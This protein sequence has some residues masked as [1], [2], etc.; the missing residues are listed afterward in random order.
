M[1]DCRARQSPEQL[2]G[3]EG[4]QAPQVSSGRSPL[5][6]P[7]WVL[8]NALLPIPIPWLSSLPS[9]QISLLFGLDRQ[10]GEGI[11]AKNRAGRE[12][13]TRHRSKRRSQKGHSIGTP[14]ARTVSPPRLS[15]KHPH[16]ETPLRKERTKPRSASRFFFSGRR[17]FWQFE[18]LA[19]LQ[20]DVPDG[21]FAK[22]F[23]S[24]I[25]LES[26]AE[27]SAGKSTRPLDGYG[28]G[29]NDPGRDGTLYFHSFSPNRTHKLHFALFIDVNRSGLDAPGN[30]ALHPDTNSSM[31]DQAS[32]H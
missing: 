28:T 16:A 6:K 1:G 13:V 12:Y 29:R 7:A 31:A 22:K 3:C 24:L 32:T 11:S 17:R 21:K 8:H 25:N 5:E 4:P 27:Q 9:V 30:F 15:P 10:L 23:A 19:L 2:H 26:A 20:L 18:Q 14:A